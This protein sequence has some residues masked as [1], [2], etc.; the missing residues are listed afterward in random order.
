MSLNFCFYQIFLHLW[1][2][3]MITVLGYARIFFLRILF[4]LFFY[5]E[6]N[7]RLFYEF[8]LTNRNHFVPLDLLLIKYFQN[9]IYLVF[10][11]SLLYEWRLL[12]F[13]NNPFERNLIVFLSQDIR[14]LTTFTSLLSPS[15]WRFLSLVICW[16]IFIHGDIL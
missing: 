10:N 8:I 11:F 1:I 3:Y 14:K 12:Y 7:N 4:S 9:N 2:S 15:P 6:K 5:V 13:Q 16:L